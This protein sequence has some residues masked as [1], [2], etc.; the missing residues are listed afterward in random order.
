[1]SPQNLDTRKQQFPPISRSR[2]DRMSQVMP[3][4]RQLEIHRHRMCHCH[5]HCHH[6]HID[7]HLLG[8]K[9]Q[10]KIHFSCRKEKTHRNIHWW[11]NKSQSFRRRTHQIQRIG[12]WPTQW[13][14]HRILKWWRTQKNVLN[15]RLD[16]PWAKKR[17]IRKHVFNHNVQPTVFTFKK[18]TTKNGWRQFITANSKR[19]YSGRRRVLATDW[20]NYPDKQGDE[21]VV[22]KDRLEAGGRKAL[23]QVVLEKEQEVFCSVW[24]GSVCSGWQF[25]G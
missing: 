4:S 8:R 14:L 3:S 7:L 25:R 13:Y 22:D 21:L 9:N 2:V 5:R 11:L 15:S 12:D 18:T 10:T 1:M 23:V 6:Q 16:L 17:I 24:K 19:V 20:R